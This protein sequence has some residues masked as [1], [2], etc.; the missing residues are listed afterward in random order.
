MLA[1]SKYEESGRNASIHA[2][3][4]YE[5]SASLRVDHTLGCTYGGFVLNRGSVS[6]AVK[7]LT[8]I[9]QIRTKVH[10]RQLPEASTGAAQCLEVE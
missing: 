9:V 6:L 10:R 4:L 1:F 5:R 7:S 8:T 3:C 2:R